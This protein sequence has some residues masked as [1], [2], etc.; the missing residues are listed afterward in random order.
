MNINTQLLL[1]L[2][3]TALGFG[4]E[5]DRSDLDASADLEGAGRAKHTVTA[6]AAGSVP[7]IRAASFASDDGDDS[8]LPVIDFPMLDQVRS[9]DLID[10]ELSFPE[11]LKKLD[12]RRVSMVGFMAPFDNLNNMRRCMILP[13]Y[14]GCNFCSPPKITQVVY[15]TQRGDDPSEIYPFIEE[16]SHINGILRL[17][18]AGSDHEGQKQGFVYALEDAI[19]TPYDGDAPVR[20]PGHGGGTASQATHRPGGMPLPPVAMDDLARKVADLLGRE[21]LHAVEFE[22]VSYEAFGDLVRNDLATTFPEATC[23]ARS[24]AFRLL[25]LLPEESDWIDTLAEFQLSRRIALAD[26]TGE[27]VYV[28]ESVSENHPYVRLELVGEIADAITRQHYPLDR[29]EP[30]TDDSDGAREQ[31]DDARRAN[32]ALRQGLRTMAL[33]RYARAHGIPPGSRPP[34]EVVQKSRARRLA[35]DEIKQAVESV[36]FSIWEAIPSYA[37]SFFVDSL[38]GDTLPLSGVDPVLAQPPSTTMEFFR[39]RW[40]HDAALWRQDPVPSDFA[41]DLMDTPPILTDVL[42]IGGLVPMLAAWYSDDVAMRLA[43][44]WA[45]DRWAM[46]QLP[47]GASALM[48]EIR[49]QDESSAI[50]FR[51]AIPD[52]SLWSLLPHEAG[53]IR[54]RM[55][56]SDS[57]D[58]IDRL[59]SAVQEANLAEEA[60]DELPRSSAVRP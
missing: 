23:A 18:L 2:L 25:G 30:G 41:D 10:S 22:A 47:D 34:V 52:D 57:A 40:Y 20:A 51:E 14:V 12:G 11:S 5:Q 27:R 55:L 29:T 1:L 45:G 4:R 15:V 60:V 53:G 17:S 59:T 37:G 8:D 36:E 16:P 32:E 7:V 38:V 13:S 6:V 3:I 58:A 42:G 50:Q 9:L 56:R 49:W 24:R 46:W 33:Y 19:V 54:V 48:L 43:G 21:P 26:E 35:D 28:L 39:P 31:S 44:G